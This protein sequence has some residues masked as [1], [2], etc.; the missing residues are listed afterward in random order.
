M[1]NKESTWNSENSS[2]TLITYLTRFKLQDG[3]HIQ[4]LQLKIFLVSFG[5]Y[6]FFSFLH[7]PHFC[8]SLFNHIVLSV[9]SAILT[10]HHLWLL[11]APGLP[12][13]CPLWPATFNLVCSYSKNVR[14]QLQSRMMFGNRPRGVYF[15]WF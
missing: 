15:W 4:M 10:N 8:V 1:E 13:I 5:L 6:L 3:L 7:C 11:M 12:M 14:G 9:S 2:N